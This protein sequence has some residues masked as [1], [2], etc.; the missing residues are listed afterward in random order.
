M[1]G[2]GNQVFQYAAALALVGPGK[3]DQIVADSSWL[4]AHASS[5]GITPR[6]FQLGRLGVAPGRSEGHAGLWYH[7]EIP[8]AYDP[9]A[10]YYLRGYFQNLIFWPPGVRQWFKDRIPVVHPR[11]RVVAIHVR[12]GDYVSNPSATTWHGVTPLVYFVHHANEIIENKLV[13]RC[14]IFS[15]DP[16]WCEKELVPK[17][18]APS[19]IHVGAMNNPWLDIADMAA[20]DYHVISNSTFGWLGAYLAESKGVVY[21]S[22]W[23]TGYKP[24]PPIFPDWWQKSEQW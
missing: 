22:K 20:C 8:P 19:S 10:K 9:A 11:A 12:R 18:R 17:L 1:G 16:D 3:E 13:D 14:S 24:A 15:D 2:L 21:P 5:P 23:L 4:E 6:P 7:E